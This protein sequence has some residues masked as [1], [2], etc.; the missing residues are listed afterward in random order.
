MEETP[1]GFGCTARARGNHR[2]TGHALTDAR[3]DAGNPGPQS[4]DHERSDASPV[5]SP[6]AGAHGLTV[7]SP[8]TNLGLAPAA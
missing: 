1:G 4:G 5:T 6:D 8:V 7:A 3:G 2:G